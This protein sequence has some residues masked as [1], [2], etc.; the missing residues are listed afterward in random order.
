MDEVTLGGAVFRIEA[1]G[2]LESVPSYGLADVAVGPTRTADEHELHLHETFGCGHW[3]Y[4]GTEEL[5]FSV[6]DLGLVSAWL[7][8]PAEGGDAHELLS[9]WT[10]R[11]VIR[12]SLKAEA[13]RPFELPHEVSRHFSVEHDLLA[14]FVADVSACG[15]RVGLEIAEGLELLFADGRYAGWLLKAPE[16]ALAKGP[17]HPGVRER[18]PELMGWLAEF[19]ALTRESVLADIE[20]GD[21][22]ETLDALRGLLDRIDLE[23]DPSERRQVLHDALAYTVEWLAD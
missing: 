22:T 15:D 5:R 3:I 8:V 2:S 19:F 18:D 16:T 10:D 6:Q 1:G 4:S 7:G 12:G 14:C 21:D 13:V 9:A 20:L 11:S 17:D 23:R